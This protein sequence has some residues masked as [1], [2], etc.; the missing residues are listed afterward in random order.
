VTV[1]HRMT[2]EPWP[3][4]AR[5]EKPQW[6]NGSSNESREGSPTS[7]ASCQLQVSQLLTMHRELLSM[8]GALLEQ[9][10]QTI[11]SLS[12]I[13]ED[14]DGPPTHYMDGTPIRG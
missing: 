9:H 1:E 12:Q 3:V 13:T 2:G 7:C 11:G 6:S 8:V 14:F 4:D 5:N 10:Q